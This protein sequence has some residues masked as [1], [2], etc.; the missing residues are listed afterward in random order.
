MD[1][2]Y[3]N[4]NRMKRLDSL[5]FEFYK[6]FNLSYQ[7]IKSQFANSIKTEDTIYPKDTLAAYSE[8]KIILADS[9]LISIIKDKE[10]SEWRLSTVCLFSQYHFSK[11]KLQLNEGYDNFLTK[12]DSTDSYES[13]SHSDQYIEYFIDIKDTD[14]FKYF[15]E[16]TFYFVD[17]KLKYISI[18]Y[19]EN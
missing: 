1:K 7:E 8:A 18:D 14:D 10:T 6:Q 11:F 13:S 2:N 19:L 3:I 9:A 15:T 5:K 4:E 16:F 12:Y 17:K